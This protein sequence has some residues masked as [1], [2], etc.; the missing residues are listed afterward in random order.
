V[1][2][3]EREDAAKMFPTDEAA[4]QH[5]AKTFEVDADYEAQTAALQQQQQAEEAAAQQQAAA[6]S[7]QA[8]GGK[9]K[10][11][12]QQELVA[13]KAAIANASVGLAHAAGHL[14]VDYHVYPGMCR[15][16]LHCVIALVPLIGTGQRPGA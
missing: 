13:I 9:S 2:Q 10:G 6:A 15:A 5:S 12:S 4:A 8:A 11:P 1:K 16:E 3:K 14:M 7:E